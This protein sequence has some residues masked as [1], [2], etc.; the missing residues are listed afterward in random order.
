VEENLVNLSAGMAVTVEIKTGSRAVITY[1]LSPL[2]RHKHET[3]T[4]HGDPQ[5]PN[6]AEA[7]VPPQREPMQVAQGRA[8]TEQ[9]AKAV[10]PPA[11]AQ[12]ATDATAEQSEDGSV[13]TPSSAP[14]ENFGKDWVVQLSAHRSEKEAQAA[15][16]AM[17]TKYSVLGGYEPKIRRK[18][19]ADRGVFYAAQVGPLARD[20]ADHLCQKLKGAG[21]GCFVQKK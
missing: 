15:F 8:S 6:P 19:R 5:E 14:G 9:S 3:L 17:R 10:E 16:R 21:A 11:I 12:L 4:T 7:V 13:G 2:M 20:E 1:L 18:D